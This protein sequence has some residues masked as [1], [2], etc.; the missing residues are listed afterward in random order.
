[1]AKDFASGLASGFAVG[2]AI[3]QRKID[4]DAALEASRKKQMED[5]AAAIETSR[6]RTVE[7]VKSLTEVLTQIITNGGDPEDPQVQKIREGIKA[8][9][10]SYGST[11]QELRAAAKA[12]GVD[13][14]LMAQLEDPTEFV[15]SQM[16]QAQAAIDA[17]LA[18]RPTTITGEELPEGVPDDIVMQKGSDGKL[19]VLFEPPQ[20]GDAEKAIEVRARFLMDSGLPEEIA[21]GIA[22]GRFELISD[23]L[24]REAQ[25]VDIGTGELVFSSVLPDPEPAEPDSIIPEN[26][27]TGDA[28]GAYG[29]GANVLN[30]LADAV[31][32]GTP[33]EGAKEAADALNTVQVVT[34]LL[35]QA[36]VPGRPAVDVRQ[37]IGKLTVKPNSLFQG[38][39]GA[40]S[41][42]TQT[43]QFID[44]NI[45]AKEQI[46]AGDM[47]PKERAD[48][49]A[50]VT[51]LKQMS[52]AHAT[53]LEGFEGGDDAVFNQGLDA[54]DEALAAGDIAKARAIREALEAGDMGKVQEL[55]GNGSD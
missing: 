2:S 26:I 12:E 46:L 28:L 27:Q 30:T 18:S 23:P 37:A 21:K 52:N 7:S 33:A 54:A 17:A 50:N 44:S 43:K 55:I 9:A 51:S 36:E 1:M 35:L 41:R 13:D 5:T 19:S 40:K 39:E 32:L 31:G 24:T 15:E 38:E 6:E 42:L 48:L 4:Q 29:V 20:A 25:V 53:L 47:D 22:G 45:A 14:A 10:M 49:Q 3:K 11:L 16:L 8:Q 34:Q